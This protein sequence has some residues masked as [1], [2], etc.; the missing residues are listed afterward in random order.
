MKSLAKWMFM[1]LTWLAL[2]VQAEPQS[3]QAPDFTLK[4]ASG[5]EIRLSDYRGKVVILHFWAT[6]CPYCKR[7]Q[8]GL[9]G[10]YQKYQQDGLELLGVSFSE[11]AGADPQG[12]LD[13]RGHQFKTLLKG[14]RV[15]RLYQVSGTPTTFF[16]DR[17]GL[18]RAVTMTSNPD[19]PGLEKMA[20]LLINEK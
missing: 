20:Q 7:L 5:E 1:S 11:D 4:D 6:W 18:L 16:I 19:E 3:Q 15:A 10:L 9:D 17:K 2:S 12:T 14:G 13:K 8:P